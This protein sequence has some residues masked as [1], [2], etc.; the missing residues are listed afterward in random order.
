MNEQMNSINLNN[1]NKDVQKKSEILDKEL[2]NLIEFYYNK[3]KENIYYESQNS[4]LG[5]ICKFEE[6][7]KEFNNN[8]INEKYKKDENTQSFIN[9]KK[10]EYHNDISFLKDVIDSWDS[11]SKKVYDIN[12]KIQDAK[13]N[14]VENENFNSYKEFK[15]YIA[16]IIETVIF[17]RSELEDIKK[18]LI[19]DENV[20]KSIKYFAGK[21]TNNKQLKELKYLLESKYLRLSENLLNEIFIIEKDIPNQINSCRKYLKENEWNN[22]LKESFRYTIQIEEKLEKQLKV[23]VNMNNLQEIEQ[24]YKFLENKCKYIDILIQSDNEGIYKKRFNSDINQMNTSMKNIKCRINNLNDIFHEFKLYRDSYLDHIKLLK[25]KNKN[26]NDLFN[27][28]LKYIEDTVRVPEQLKNINNNINN[29]QKETYLKCNLHNQE[30]QQDIALLSQWS[31]YYRDINQNFEKEN[32]KV[33]YKNIIKW[34]E[35]I[36]NLKKEYQNNIKN[37]EYLNTYL[38]NINNLFK[39]K[40]KNNDYISIYITQLK[41]CEEF[42]R[43]LNSDGATSSYILTNIT[44]CEKRINKVFS[45]IDR[46]YSDIKKEANNLYEQ[47]IQFSNNK[48]I[49]YLEHCSEKYKINAEKIFINDEIKTLDNLLKIRRLQFE[50]IFSLLKFYNTQ[51]NKK[52]NDITCKFDSIFSNDDKIFLKTINDSMKIIKEREKYQVYHKEI[53]SKYSELKKDLTEINKKIKSELDEEWKNS[54]REYNALASELKNMPKEIKQ[55]CY[56]NVPKLNDLEELELCIKIENEFNNFINIF[57]EKWNILVDYK[58]KIDKYEDNNK[59]EKLNENE[60]NELQDICNII[61]NTEVTFKSLS[62]ILTTSYTSINDKNISAIIDI[63]DT[64]VEKFENFKKNILI[65]NNKYIKVSLANIKNEATENFLK[66]SLDWCQKKLTE[67]NDYKYSIRAIDLN[68][69][70]EM[71]DCNFETD[72][73]KFE[74]YDVSLTC[75]VNYFMDNDN[76]ILKEQNI[77]F[78]DNYEIISEKKLEFEKFFSTLLYNDFC[79]EKKQI[80]L[81]KYSKLKEDLQEWKIT[82]SDF[83]MACDC[84]EYMLN[85]LLFINLADKKLDTLHDLLENTYKDY[86]SFH[87]GKLILINIKNDINQFNFEIKKIY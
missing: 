16:K 33:E 21:I 18:Q 34:K 38:M 9:F 15:T 42:N 30:F 25:T 5:K 50:K 56:F 14:N 49:N 69:I 61:G 20:N 67:I 58:G 64:M 72:S 82:L 39:Q 59:W 28:S 29:F 60:I 26:L 47:F 74:D 77:S 37:L 75:I 4:D 27:N 73:N 41:H 68:P 76:K 6:Y 24:D 8:S 71:Y 63:Q 17:L 40:I 31:D 52:S 22:D 55:W 51:I 87:R 13:K 83:E 81:E 84:K 11:L 1:V 44:K 43:I 80:V 2:N 48:N 35:N 57:I 54:C 79:I 19:F 86:E 85:M 65:I 10:T 23:E 45:T 62:E 78:N 7:T 36:E 3:F 32:L 46:K 66:N 70:Y 12:E 53:N